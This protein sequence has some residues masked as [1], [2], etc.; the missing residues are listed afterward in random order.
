MT[1]DEQTPRGTGPDGERERMPSRA[2]REIER[3]GGLFARRTHGMTSSAMRD[4]MAVTEPARGDLAGRRPAGHDARSR[5]RTSSSLMSAVAR[6][7]ERRRPCSTGRPRGCPRTSWSCIVEVMAAEGMRRRDRRPAGHHRRPAGDR[8]RLPH[9]PRSRRRRDR[10]GADLSRR[11]PVLRLLPGRRRPDRDGRRR[12]AHRRAGG[13]A[14]P[15]ARRRAQA[16]VHLHDAVLPEP[17]AA[18]RCRSSAAAS[19]CGSPRT[20]S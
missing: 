13:D 4:L 9:V 8:P 6:R 12:H 17:G 15:P 3:Y 11:R 2:P 18:S 20:A 7:L 10:R 1:I 5:P 19:S 16:E 14:R